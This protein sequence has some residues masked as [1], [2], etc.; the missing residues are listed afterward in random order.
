[1]N[2]RREQWQMRVSRRAHAATWLPPQ[3]RR[4]IT[5]PREVLCGDEEIYIY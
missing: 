5:Q 1:M 4:A 3:T 2:N